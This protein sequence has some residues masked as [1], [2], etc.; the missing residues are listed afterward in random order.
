VPTTELTWPT[1]V[2]ELM[3]GEADRDAIIATME[4]QLP[5]DGVAAG[6]LGGRFSLARATY[7]L[8][9]SRILEAAAASLE[10]DVAEPL[11]GWLANFQNMREAAAKTLGGD[12]EVAVTLKKPVPFTSKQAV[13]VSLSVGGDKVASV[14]FRLELTI[15][16]GETSVAVRHG[17]IEELVVAVCCAS[18][19]FT[20]DGCPKPLWKPEPV[21]LPD[22]RLVVRPPFRL[23][24]VPVPRPPQES[25]RLD[26]RPAA[27]RPPVPGRHREPQP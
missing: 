22:A 3:C 4:R 18:A 15:E 10:Q 19:S 2:K 7:R 17:A 13:L 25:D 27:Q 8:L 9:D 26:E 6:R 23:P 12:D 24:L 20:L 14:A 1:T 5:D 11:V 21:K 16:L